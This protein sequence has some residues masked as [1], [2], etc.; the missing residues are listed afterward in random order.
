MAAE[1][2][3]APSGMKVLSQASGKEFRLTTKLDTKSGNY[4]KLSFSGTIREAQDT[5]RLSGSKEKINIVERKLRDFHNNRP[6]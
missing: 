4:S 5:A 3:C 1:C 6:I 2:S